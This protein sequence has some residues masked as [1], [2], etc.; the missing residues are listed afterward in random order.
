MGTT[1]T[2]EGSLDG[3]NYTALSFMD[4]SVY[5]DDA[6]ADLPS[7]SAGKLMGLN[8]SGLVKVKLAATAWFSGTMGV[9][10]KGAAG[11]RCTDRRRLS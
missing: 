8:C 7:Q 9:I 2:A 5:A 3:T 6:D 11:C 1:D 10:S 4:R